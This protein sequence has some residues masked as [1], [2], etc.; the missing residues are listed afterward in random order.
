MVKIPQTCTGQEFLL[1]EE[2]VEDWIDQIPTEKAE[3]IFVS[4]GVGT[5]DGS[6]FCYW[7]GQ[8]NIESPDVL[9]AIQAHMNNHDVVGIR[10]V[11][12]LPVR[13]HSSLS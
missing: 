8:R 12:D 3:D 5:I 13:V 2:T 7:I 4:E 1:V 9:S 10:Y 11:R 6:V